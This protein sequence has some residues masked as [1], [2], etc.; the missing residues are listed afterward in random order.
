M[1]RIATAGG[2]CLDGGDAVGGADELGSFPRIEWVD[3]EFRVGSSVQA[4]V[5]ADQVAHRRDGRTADDD[6]EMAL[7]RQGVPHRGEYVAEVT[8]GAGESGGFVDHQDQWGLDGELDEE[9]QGSFE[10]GETS[11]GQRN[12]VAEGA[13]GGLVQSTE[14]VRLGVVTGRREVDGWQGA[15]ELRQQEGFADPPPPPHHGQLRP[16]RLDP[17]PSRAQLPKFT[18]SSK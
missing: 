11:P 2:V 13:L 17:R 16:T 18:L 3:A 4:P 6:E 8:P 12:P 10:V 9:S 15:G 14:L 5:G 7:C 1:H